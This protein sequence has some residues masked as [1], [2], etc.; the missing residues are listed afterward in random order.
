MVL[1]GTHLDLLLQLL[2]VMKGV[3]QSLPLPCRMGWENLHQ[4]PALQVTVHLPK[5]SKPFLLPTSA[6]CWGHR[7]HCGGTFLAV[8][9]KEALRT[10]ADVRV[11]VN[12]AGPPIQAGL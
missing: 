4:L 2:G 8:H 12:L 10:L 5:R 6:R 9:A 7:E 1:Y 11:V 3:M